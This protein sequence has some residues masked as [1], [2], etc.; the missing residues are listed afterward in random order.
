MR[1]RKPVRRRWEGRQR[2]Y[3]RAYVGT[4]IASE[5]ETLSLGANEPYRSL[6]NPLNDVR[7]QKD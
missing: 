1:G 4:T 2:V 5:R 7:I 3:G 6:G